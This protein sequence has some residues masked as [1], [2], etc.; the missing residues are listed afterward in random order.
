MTW[1][2]FWSY[3][4]AKAQYICF[5]LLH[6]GWRGRLLINSLQSLQNHMWSGKFGCTLQK[7]MG[8]FWRLSEICIKA[9]FWQKF[10]ILHIFRGLYIIS[11]FC[12]TFWNQQNS[13]LICQYP[14]LR[15][16]LHSHFLNWQWLSDYIW[17]IKMPANIIL[18]PWKINS[19]LSHLWLR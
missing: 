17:D 16:Q 10:K 6:C 1:N 15:F 9:F 11:T 3:Y 18:L 4:S 13:S 8:N 2:A 19:S 5:Q 14:S 7:F 12:L